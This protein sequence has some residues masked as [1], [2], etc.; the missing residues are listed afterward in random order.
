MRSTDEKMKILKHIAEGNSRSSREF[1]QNCEARY[2]NGEA[3]SS[4][5]CKYRLLN[6]GGMQMYIIHL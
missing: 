5:Q 6:E 1:E 4:T 2:E 3:Y